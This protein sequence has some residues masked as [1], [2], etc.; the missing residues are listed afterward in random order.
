MNKGIPS[1]GSWGPIGP[2]VLI[3]GPTRGPN[4][5]VIF[6]DWGKNQVVIF[7]QIILVVILM[8]FS[9]K[10][11]GFSHSEGTIMQCTFFES[12]YIGIF[13]DRIF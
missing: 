3:P 13:R 8:T 7:I 12:K 11:S 1:R 10:S 4:I 2:F 5:I 9:P 6:S